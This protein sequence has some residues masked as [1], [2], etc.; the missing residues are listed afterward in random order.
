[1]YGRVRTG[2]L[3][4]HTHAMSRESDDDGEEEDMEVVLGIPWQYHPL[5]AFLV[6]KLVTN[7]IPVNY[8]LMGPLDVW[9]KYCDNDL[10][11][12]ME[13][14]DAFKRRLLSL[15]HQVKEGKSRAAEDLEAFNIAKANHP[16]SQSNHRDE[17]QWNGSEAQRLLEID[18][19]AK[20]HFDLKPEH[21]WESRDDYQLFYLETFRNH[22]HQADQTR[23]YLY[24]LKM[25]Q[26][27][28]EDERK[29]KARKKTEAEAARKQ[30]AEEQARAKAEKEAEKKRK[31]EAKAVARKEKEE[32]RAAEKKEKEEARAAV[33]KEKAAAKAVAKG[34]KEAAKTANKRKNN[35]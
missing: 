11:E 31:E 28:K 21:L 5:R 2:W 20:K 33:R 30:K 1:M 13:Y 18:M 15:R 25:R 9:N 14:D 16:P 19:N 34:K 29:E 24:T 26:K 10:F 3:T 6:D 12:G 22:L 4:Y 8:K 17:P 32:K 7:D 27:E 23:K 35:K